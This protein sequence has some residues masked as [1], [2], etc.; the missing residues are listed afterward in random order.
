[1]AAEGLK[2]RNQGREPAPGRCLPHLHLH[3]AQRPPGPG[4]RLGRDARCQ[5]LCMAWAGGAA[6][7]SANQGRWLAA[8]TPAEVQA[9]WVLEGA[10][11]GTA[12]SEYNRV[13]DVLQ[14]TPIATQ[15]CQASCPHKKCGLGGAPFG[16]AFGWCL[17]AA[18]GCQ[19]AQCP[20]LPSHPLPTWAAPHPTEA[21]QRTT[22][23][24]DGHPLPVPPHLILWPIHGRPK[25]FVLIAH[26]CGL[27]NGFPLHGRQKTI[28]DRGGN[29]GLR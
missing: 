4:E 23:V 21:T 27:F 16:T 3:R 7:I 15:G 18:G 12:R 24:T 8:A 2:L 26:G 14:R 25:I 11:L 1:V 10:V 6:R 22:R 17:K 19:A 28:R 29:H 13:G 20:P 5:G 9:G